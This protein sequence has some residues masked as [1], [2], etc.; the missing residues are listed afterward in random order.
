MYELNQAPKEWAKQSAQWKKDNHN[1]L[2]HMPEGYCVQP[3][4]DGVLVIIDPQR[5]KVRTRQ[6]EYLTSMDH[7]FDLI[8]PGYHGV[9]FGEAWIPNSDFKTIS[10]KVRRKAPQPDVGVVLFDAVGH[11]WFEEGHCPTPY[12]IRFGDAAFAANARQQTGPLWLAHSAELPGINLLH[13]ADHW[14][15]LGGCDGVIARALNAEWRTGACKN[16]EVIKVKPIVS[17]D[18]RVVGWYPGK[19]KHAGKAGGLYVTCNGLMQPVGTGLSDEERERAISG[20]FDGAIAEIECME[21][22][23]SGK[24]REPRVKGFRFDKDTPDA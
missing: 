14:K 6:G 20:C 15:S 24:L 21:V 4:Y 8:N 19:G 22:N 12:T 16:G 2:T 7:I 1:F 5:R 11:E 17:L 10:G 23:A 18:L 9:L 13:E 3:K